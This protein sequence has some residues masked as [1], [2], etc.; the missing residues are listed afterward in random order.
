MSPE[1]RSLVEVGSRARGF[2]PLALLALISIETERTFRTDFGAERWSVRDTS[3][4]FLGW[5]EPAARI[6][7]IGPVKERPHPGVLTEGAWSTWA[8]LRML[9]GEQVAL[10][11]RTLERAFRWGVPKRPV[12]YYLAAWGAAPGLSEGTVIALRGERKYQRRPEL[13]RNGDGRID[14]SDLRALIEGRMWEIESESPAPSSKVG[15]SF[16]DVIC[17]LGLGVLRARRGAL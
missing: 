10:T 1:V 3:S 15:L 13:D 6:L 9:P 8:V 12:D 7:D 16:F 11:M 5:T 17:S 2:D 4:G 14:V